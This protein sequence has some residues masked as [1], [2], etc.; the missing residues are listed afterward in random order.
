[1]TSPIANWNADS[2]VCNFKLLVILMY[3]PHKKILKAHLSIKLDCAMWEFI[4]EF[5]SDYNSNH[6]CNL[7]Q[8]Y[9]D[10][11]IFTYLL[12]RL[13]IYC[14]SHHHL[15]ERDV[16]G[17]TLN[18]IRWSSGLCRGPLHCHY[19]RSTLA[20]EWWYLLGSHLWVK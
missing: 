9:P 19:S 16:L 18:C 8:L 4:D 11:V 2:H 7:L 17:M 10:S 13:R 3:P 14:A 1:M 20:L 5:K 15:K 12:A 6:C